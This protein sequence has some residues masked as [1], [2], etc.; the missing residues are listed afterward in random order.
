MLRLHSTEGAS[1]L[2]EEEVPR[3]V[4]VSNCVKPPESARVP[5]TALLSPGSPRSPGYPHLEDLI[6]PSSCQMS[7]FGSSMSSQLSRSSS[8]T[9]GDAAISAAFQSQEQPPLPLLWP[10]PSRSSGWPEVQRAKSLPAQRS[11]SVRSGRS[12]SPPPKATASDLS[13]ASTT[14]SGA[15]GL[16]KD[17]SWE[18]L[19]GLA[20]RIQGTRTPEGR[21]RVGAET[22]GRR[23]SR[24][25][26]PA[27]APRKLEG[28][29]PSPTT[30]RKVDALGRSLSPV[31]SRSIDLSESNVA[32][33]RPGLH[34]DPRYVL[35]LER[36]LVRL[37]AENLR[38]RRRTPPGARLT[39]EARR[40]TAAPR[41]RGKVAR[42][43]STP[44]RSA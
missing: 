12:L 7:S 27:V 36:E 21:G 17:A 30:P 10:L 42:N 26:R 1:D 33:G 28:R 15:V 40:P 8:A 23:V 39:P 31:R 29:R 20:R 41:P 6:Q 2:L 43:E 44:N 19:A 22:H 3:T 25:Q 38:L 35:A 34:L 16:F 13:S 5:T 4:A 11:G 18:S 32:L 9:S 24:P 37:R 14:I